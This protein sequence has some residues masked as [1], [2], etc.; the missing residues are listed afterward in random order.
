M[1]T[2]DDFSQSGGSTPQSGSNNKTRVVIHLVGS[3]PGSGK[4][5]IIPPNA[6]LADVLARATAKLIPSGA[7]NVTDKDASASSSEA[8]SSAASSAESTVAL[9][10]V[11]TVTGAEITDAEEIMPDDVLFFSS[12][13]A[14]HLAPAPVSP[15]FAPPAAAAAA[16][17]N[18]NNNNNNDDH[19]NVMNNGSSLASLSSSAAPPQ[20]NDNNFGPAEG[21]PSPAPVNN[22]NNNSYDNAAAA[23][24]APAAPAAAA[25]A[26]AP[27]AAREPGVL[28]LLASH[29][30]GLAT[31]AYST[32]AAYLKQSGPAAVRAG[33]PEWEARLFP[34]LASATAQSGPALDWADDQL[35]AARAGFRAARAEF[36][37]SEAGR[38]L[39][40]SLAALAAAGADAASRTTAA[41]AASAEAFYDTASEAFATLRARGQEGAVAA[42]EHLALVKEKLGHAW[43]EQLA[44][45]ARGVYDIWQARQAAAAYAEAQR[46]PFAGVAA[47]DARRYGLSPNAANAHSSGAGDAMEREYAAVAA[48]AV[49]E[50]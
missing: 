28:R 25:A 14:S 48:A 36:L 21:I 49:A 1:S 8:S 13:S 16:D 46:A 22:N 34:L 4:A 29:A 38:N 50:V 23:A 24:A 2:N 5:M 37:A 45:A 41:G 12:A 19:G 31:C 27:P 6:T 17:N 7:N 42:A 47:G 39:Q 15:L 10:H 35:L 18:N 20:Y 44:P 9:R 43:N 30:A 3:T 40:A 32:A 33:L 26:D 11:Y